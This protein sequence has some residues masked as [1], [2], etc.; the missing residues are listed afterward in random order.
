MP[1]VVIYG[2]KKK[3]VKVLDGWSFIQLTSPVK[4]GDKWF[5]SQTKKWEDIEDIE[6]SPKLVPIIRRCNRETNKSYL[7]MS[8]HSVKII[9]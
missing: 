8:P 4:K 9:D 3:K 6:L 7:D 2:E 1:Q 5:N